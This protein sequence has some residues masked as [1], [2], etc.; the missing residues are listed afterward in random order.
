MQYMRVIF[1]SVENAECPVSN[2]DTV[3]SILASQKVIQ[4]K[5]GLYRITQSKKTLLQTLYIMST[6]RNL[7]IPNQNL[8]K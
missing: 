8:L 1:F 2:H 6:F 4:G 3:K 7:N 5:S